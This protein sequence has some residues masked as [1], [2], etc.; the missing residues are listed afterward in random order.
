MKHSQRGT[1]D[2]SYTER[3]ER[4]SRAAWK[5]KIDVQAPYRWNLRRLTPDRVLDVGCGLGRNLQHLGGNGVGVDH[6]ATSVAVARQSGLT[7]FTP[8]EFH[9]SEHAVRQGFD[10]LLV[11]HVLEHLD[12]QVA[13][14]LLEEYLPFVRPGGQVIV[15]T[16]QE[17]GYATDETH[18]RFVDA[19][20][21]A[22]HLAGVGVRVERSYSF[23]FPRPVGKVFPYNEFVV[24]GR[25]PS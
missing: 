23:P 3:L 9:R 2:V 22:G 1:E 7:A 19:T 10:A 20:G 5:T 21:I 6:N 8:Q 11:A 18:V 14:G 12:E 4:L 16:P 17:R 24:T 15:I 25:V 13:N